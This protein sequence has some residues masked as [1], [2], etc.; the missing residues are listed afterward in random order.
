MK[1]NLFLAAII[2][3]ASLPSKIAQISPSIP[4]DWFSLFERWG[5]AGFGIGAFVWT[6]LYSRKKDADSELERKAER[7]Y[8]LE[9]ISKKDAAL[10]EANDKLIQYL[11]RQP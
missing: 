3:F 10:K 7:L 6:T 1:E 9:T 4:N 2:T 8:L 5:I 11:T